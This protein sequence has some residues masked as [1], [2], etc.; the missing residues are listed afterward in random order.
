M[1]CVAIDPL[2]QTIIR[3]N[4]E[5]DQLKLFMG[6]TQTNQSGPLRNVQ[7][8]LFQCS[9]PVSKDRCRYVIDQEVSRHR[10]W[11]IETYKLNVFN[12]CQSSSTIRG[13][14]RV[15]DCHCRRSYKDRFTLIRCYHTDQMR[16]RQTD[17][18]SIFRCES[19]K[20]NYKWNEINC[21]GQMNRSLVTHW[22]C[23]IPRALW[24]RFHL[25]SAR[26]CRWSVS[27]FDR[28]ILIAQW[29]SDH[30]RS[31]RRNRHRSDIHRR[32]LS[33]EKENRLLT[34]KNDSRIH[35]W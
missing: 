13:E 20:I 3:S 8:D 27:R 25:R 4:G 24:R 15:F 2:D 31:D 23:S 28:P 19:V 18:S 26:H 16:R 21:S 11:S 30:P 33:L 34:A 14:H 35:W 7:E 12:F 5:K 1:R 10:Q 29:V 32:C 6:H 22:W 9:L 17:G